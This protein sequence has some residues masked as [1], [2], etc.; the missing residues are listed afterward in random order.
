MRSL[1]LFPANH[2]TD[3]EWTLPDTIARVDDSD[4][5]AEFLVNDLDGRP[6]PAPNGD[7]AS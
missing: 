3:E 6:K 4:N 5:F 7:G 2:R 1:G